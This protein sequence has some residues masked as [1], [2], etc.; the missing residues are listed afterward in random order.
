MARNYSNVPPK[1]QDFINSQRPAS[2]M[3]VVGLGVAAAAFTARAAIRWSKP[4]M[5][6]AKKF[7]KAVPLLNSHYYRGGFEPKM[8]KREAALVLGVSPSANTKKMREAHRRIMLLNHP[9]RG[10]SPYLAAKINEAKDLLEGGGTK[11]PLR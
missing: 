10:G 1:Q 8:T 3:I 7:E 6:S 2:T 9:D 5:E 4:L 11:S